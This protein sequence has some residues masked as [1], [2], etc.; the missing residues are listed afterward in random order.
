MQ[1]IQEV[2]GGLHMCGDASAVIKASLM[3]KRRG[4]SSFLHLGFGDES[5]I[6]SMVLDNSGF[7]LELGFSGVQYTN[8]I[9]LLDLK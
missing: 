8:A 3:T 2:A 4:G 9:G 6:F 5:E 7:G 1:W